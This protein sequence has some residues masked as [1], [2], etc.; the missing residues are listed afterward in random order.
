MWDKWIQCISVHFVLTFWFKCF[1][2]LS[3]W[4]NEQ[5]QNKNK[6]VAEGMAN[7]RPWTHTNTGHSS[8]TGAFYT[9]T[10][11]TLTRL[12]SHS[13]AQTTSKRA[14]TIALQS[15]TERDRDM[16]MKMKM[17]F[18]LPRVGSKRQSS[19]IMWPVGF[20][21]PATSP[22]IN[23]TSVSN[24]YH[25]PCVSVLLYGIVFNAMSR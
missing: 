4:I 10:Y 1:E 21:V 16:K 8:L 14:H 25:F 11:C 17:K 2:R 7:S 24:W 5:K 15:H 23:I 20:S 9:N 12:H 18:Y 22:S 13:R 6:I 3:S 19:K